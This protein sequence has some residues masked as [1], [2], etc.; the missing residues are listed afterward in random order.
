MAAAAAA[1]EAPRISQISPVPSLS[2]GSIPSLWEA[3]GEG[4]VDLLFLNDGNYNPGNVTL[5]VKNL[6]GRK[7]SNP[8][9]MSLRHER[10]GPTDV[11]ETPF[12]LDEDGN[13][14]LFVSSYVPDSGLYS[15]YI[16]TAVLLD[17]N[18]YEKNREALA[19]PAP[20]FWQVVDLD[21]NGTPTFVQILIRP[22]D[23]PTAVVKLWKRTSPGVLEPWSDQTYPI[24]MEQTV[25]D[26]LV[27]AVDIDGDGDL[28]L[29]FDGAYDSKAVLER[30][31]AKSFA[32]ETHSLNLEGYVR[33]VDLDGDGLSDLLVVGGNFL[34]YQ[35]NEGG[36]NFS[37][38]DSHIIDPDDNAS[39]DFLNITSHQGSPA[40]L[41]YAR[42]ASDEVKGDFI[43]V[44]TYRFGTWEEISRYAIWQ[45]TDHPEITAPIV[46]ALQDLDG[47][48][49][50]DVLLREKAAA[51]EAE[52]AY[53]S[54]ER[55]AVAWGSAE[56]YADPVFITGSP[57]RATRPATGDFDRDGDPDLVI[58]P[59]QEGRLYFMANDGKGNFTFRRT[60]DEL[61]PAW[62]VAEGGKVSGMES[63]DLNRDGKPD[64]AV[65]Y[66]KT[67]NGEF[68]SDYAVVTALN[69]GDGTFTVPA[70]QTINRIRL[71][72]ITKEA[73]AAWRE[74]I[75]ARVKPR[76]KFPSTTELRALAEA[77]RT[78]A[79]Q[80][81]PLSFGPVQEFVDMDRDGDP[82]ELVTNGW[83][84]N[85]RGEF[86][87]SLLPLLEGVEGTDA[88]GNL[89][90]IAAFT[91]GDLDGDRI[92]DIIS[93]AGELNSEIPY[94]EYPWYEILSTRMT[95][96][97]RDRRGEVA[98]TTMVDA[99]C[100]ASDALGSFKLYGR[101]AITDLDNDGD[102]DLLTYEQT[103]ADALGNVMASARWRSNPG[104]RSRDP[105]NWYAADLDFPM[106]AGLWHVD[107]DGDG[108]LDWAS[109]TAFLT[110]TNAGPR[111]ESG[112]DFYG[113]VSFPPVWSTS[114][115]ETMADFDGDGDADI[116]RSEGDGRLFLI[117]NTIIDETPAPAAAKPK[118]RT[119]AR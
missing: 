106:E 64:L 96:G 101:C 76:P 65:H 27:S 9:V 26:G 69:K 3:N 115:V 39:W 44:V 57:L 112:Y 111:V 24:P 40:T 55:L 110:P 114:K 104:K 71:T 119:R 108:R 8:F 20:G 25:G 68:Q 94:P 95:V 2:I 90:I 75:R 34:S 12:D 48:G 77:D 80:L 60:L 58:G 73:T 38:T 61:L 93:L 102:N 59:D 43:E 32:A 16:P 89:V 88:F 42:Y 23:E 46:L 63:V 100:A 28:D 5:Q 83:R 91:A 30:T 72:R 11:T 7:F 117:R 18:G 74:Q 99:R 66:A 31:A 51:S 45:T 37:N 85:D 21:G 81:L 4:K 10:N 22:D 6:G 56:G 87:G 33:W 118:V 17:A 79:M 97:Y 107:F 103:G 14:D 29:A 98:S 47:D 13:L 84:K 15:A 52:L 82:D 1:G 49:F 113:Y 92:P 35:F 41:N 116:L 19:A 78:P 70:F 105:Q 109:D 67:V 62:L 50:T 86:T 53:F 36:F 54:A